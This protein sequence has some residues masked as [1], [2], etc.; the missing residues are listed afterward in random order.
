MDFLYRKS[1][2]ELAEELNDLMA[3]LED[4]RDEAQDVLEEGED[5]SVRAD[6][7]RM[8]AAIRLLS[9]AAD[10]LEGEEA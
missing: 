8:D 7:Q 10:Q 2:D 9:Q 6:V 4:I 5:A 3:D 1:L